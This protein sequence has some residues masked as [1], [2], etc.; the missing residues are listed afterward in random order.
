MAG[1][2]SAAASPES[3]PPLRVRPAPATAFA[4]SVLPVPGGPTSSSPLGGRA[5]RRVNLS[6]FLK[7]SCSKCRA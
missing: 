1:P 2:G 6:G 3:P 5:P 7:N 4:S